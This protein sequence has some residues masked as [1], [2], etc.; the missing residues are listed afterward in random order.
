M[1]PFVTLIIASGSKQIMKTLLPVFFLSLI[2]FIVLI[3]DIFRK[4][5]SG[6]EIIVSCILYFLD[7]SLKL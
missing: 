6:I 5:V 2:Y 7:I 1:T 4:K 3:I